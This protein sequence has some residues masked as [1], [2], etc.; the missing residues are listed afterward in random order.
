[1]LQLLRNHAKWIV[2]ATLVFFVGTIGSGLYFSRGLFDSKDSKSGAAIGQLGGITVDQ[3]RY[4]M[5][6]SKVLAGINQQDLSHL[7]PELAE[8][9]Q[10]SAFRQALQ[11]A[12]LLKGATDKG[13]R[14]SS[15]E[16][17]QSL[18]VV[19][20]D[21]NVKGKRELKALLKK[22]NYPYAEFKDALTEDLLAQKF[23]QSLMSAVKVSTQDVYDS[24]TRA[25][26]QHLLLRVSDPKQETAVLAKIQGIKREIQKGLSFDEAVTRYSDDIKSRQKHGDL[27]WIKWGQTQSSFEQVAFRIPFGQLSDPVRT[28]FGYHLLRVLDRQVSLSATLN[29]VQEKAKVLQAKQSRIVQDYMST[30]MASNTLVM[31][32]LVLKAYHAKMTGDLSGA[33][34]AYNALQSVTPGS[35][36]PH[37]LLAKVYIAND[38]L[39][40]AAAEYK[41]ADLKAK[42]SP[43]LDSLSFR[44]AYGDFLGKRG[45]MALRD[46]Q[47]DH[48]LALSK[49]NKRALTYLVAEFEKRKLMSFVQKTKR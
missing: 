25:H 7:D 5:A 10:Y 26:V 43:T 42:L 44:L 4:G 15:S 36:V 38:Q 28:D 37:Y 14:V 1:M 2:M 39:T 27:D 3:S 20:R 24:F 12:I 33:I 21:Y 34:G 47:Y 41:K 35:P 30:I 32:D 29:V 11:Q 48:A 9:V 46:V 49:G 19:Y 16:Y 22:S 45:D 13:V 31:Q 8:L 17:N 40:L 23:T 18:E 6:L